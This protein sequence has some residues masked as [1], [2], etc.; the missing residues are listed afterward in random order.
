MGNGPRYIVTLLLAAAG[1]YGLPWLFVVAGGRL[2]S[3][4]EFGESSA[5]ALLPIVACLL[6]YGI[7]LALQGKVFWGL[8]LR[9]P[10]ALLVLL[11]AAGAIA[12]AWTLPLG[13]YF[14]GTQLVIAAVAYCGFA[15]MSLLTIRQPS[16]RALPATT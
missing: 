12:V 16:R 8:T 2:R 15:W 13:S 5:A 3:S 9:W 7:L 10:A 11:V 4:L 14:M 1:C 6:A